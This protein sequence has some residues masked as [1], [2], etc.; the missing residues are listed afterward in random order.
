MRTGIHTG[1]PGGG[2]VFAPTKLPGCVLWLRGD[3]G[4]TSPDTGISRWLDQSASLAHV[5]QD[6]AANKGAR[7]GVGAAQGI[8]FDGTADNLIGTTIAALNAAYTVGIAVQYRA[9]DVAANDYIFGNG[10]GGNGC[11]FGTDDSVGVAYHS[12]NHPGVGLLRYSAATTNPETWVYRHDGAAG[13]SDFTL[14]GVHE[15]GQA[16]AQM[17]APGGSLTV[18]SGHLLNGASNAIVWAIIAYSTRLSDADTL[19]LN[20]YLTDLRNGITPTVAVPGVPVLH[21]ERPDLWAG[22]SVS[23]WADQETGTAYDFAQAVAANMP[24]HIKGDS[25]VP[26]LHLDG[27]ADTVTR[28][29]IATLATGYTSAVVAQGEAWTGSDTLFGEGDPGGPDGWRMEWDNTPQVRMNH[30]GVAASGWAACGAGRNRVIYAHTGA[31]ASLSGNINGTP[32]APAALAVE[33]T[34]HTGSAAVGARTAGG[35]FNTH[36]QGRIHEVIGYSAALSAAEQ[37][38]LAAYLTGLHA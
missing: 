5:S 13:N 6:T 1:I 25:A 19:Q 32:V 21:L 26:F 8:A 38:A 15:V 34:P 35:G 20:Q 33:S 29:A 16:L 2:G 3:L 9:L 12:V 37:A 22:P 31:G 10:T 30:A 27:V 7:N 18:G 36:T 17:G 24:A 28:A 23:A 11:R 4:I 14:N